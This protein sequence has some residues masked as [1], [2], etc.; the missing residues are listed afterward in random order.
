MVAIGVL[1]AVLLALV[2]LVPRAFGGESDDQA[3]D[4]GRKAG[5]APAASTGG[6]P[7]AAPSSTAAAAPAPTTAKPS[8]PP[9]SAAASKPATTG[10]VPAGWRLYQGDGYSVPI[11]E[12]AEVRPDGTEVYFTKNNRLLIIDH[13]EQPKPDPVA[14]WKD[15]EA[16]RKGSKYKDY[17]RIRLE[18]LTYLGKAADWEFTYHHGERQPAARGE[19]GLHHHAGQAGVQHLLVHLAG[20]LGGQPEGPSGHLPGV[21]GES[22]GLQV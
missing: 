3:G 20:G 22:V 19:A 12:G 1:V 4:D 14:D 13:S 7:S 6:K 2:L 18:G 15:Q 10:K 17:Q 11:P 8:A 9:S 21:Q 16:D 5:V